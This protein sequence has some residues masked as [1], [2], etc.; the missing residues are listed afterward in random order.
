MRRV[1]ISFG[2]V[3]YSVSFRFSVYTFCFVSFRF[4]VLRFCFVSH[5]KGTCFF[6]FYYLQKSVCL[7]LIFQLPSPIKLT[8]THNL[9]YKSIRIRSIKIRSTKST[10]IFICVYIVYC[11]ELLTCLFRNGSFHCIISL[12]GLISI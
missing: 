5:F 4:V 1:H 3:V 9:E 7:L 10:Y 8:N 12:Y 2:F 6:S 11:Y